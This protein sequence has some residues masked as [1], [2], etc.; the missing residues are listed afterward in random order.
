[1]QKKFHQKLKM[2]ESIE[3]KNLKKIRSSYV[4]TMKR[5]KQIHEKLT[6]I[7]K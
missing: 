1:M 2:V 7:E 6:Q 4:D 5:K 3:R